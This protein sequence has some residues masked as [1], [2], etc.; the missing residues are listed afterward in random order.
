[1][2]LVVCALMFAVGARAASAAVVVPP[3]FADACGG[4]NNLDYATCERLDYIVQ[5]NLDSES[6]L[7]G[8]LWVIVGAIAAGAIGSSF[9][10]AVLWRG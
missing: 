2:L 1:M 4:S 7:H 3:A 9:L 6:V 5:E 8:D 10:H